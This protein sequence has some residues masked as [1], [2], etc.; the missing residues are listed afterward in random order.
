MKI[1]NILK[2]FLIVV[3]P[4]LILGFNVFEKTEI[5]SSFINLSGAEFAIKNK[6]STNFGDPKRL[7]I[8]S[9]DDPE[10]EH[11]WQL[12]KDNSTYPLPEKQPMI[13][14]RLAIENGAYVTLSNDKKIVLVPDNTP[15]YAIMKS[16]EV[17]SLGSAT[18]KDMFMIGTIGDIK[19]WLE[20]KKDHIR[21]VR[22]LIVTLISII[23]GIVVEFGWKD[24]KRGQKLKFQNITTI[25]LKRR[26][27]SLPD[28]PSISPP[29]FN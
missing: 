1:K 26:Q 6:L 29:N 28:N 16:E 12:I 11:L 20:V 8:T 3:F 9:Q 23:L 27:K 18:E 5:Y 13:I 2:L 25:S 4:I 14:S 10:F 24:T 19:K 22:D 21:S 17:V 15:V 7:I